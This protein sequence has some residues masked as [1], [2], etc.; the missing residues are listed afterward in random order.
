V[1]T[2]LDLF[3]GYG[4]FALAAHWAGYTTI[5]FCEI[6]PWLR[7]RLAENFPGVPQHDDI[8]TLEA[9]LVRHWIRAATHDDNAPLH[10][11][12]GGYPCQPFSHAGKRRGTDDDRH[13]W[14]YLP[15]LIAELR[16]ERILLENV[17]GHVRMGLDE[18]LSDLEDLGYASAPTVLPAAAVNAPHRRDRIWI[19]C[20]RS[21][22]SQPACTATEL[23]PALL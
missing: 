18:V 23:Q 19:A 20:C 11:L 17:S 15:P 21:D 7:E 6:D 12:T 1:R 13:L 3:S 2:H 14:P 10:L 16:P 9:D 8:K 22:T 4:G 5:G